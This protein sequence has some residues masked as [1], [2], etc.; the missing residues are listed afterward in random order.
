[1]ID[2]VSNAKVPTPA[3]LRKYGLSAEQWY[4]IWKLQGKICPICKK[5][6][7]TGKTVVDH[8]HYKNWKKLSADVRRS[9]VRGICC[10]YCNRW[11]VAK[12]MNIQKA[13]N[14]VA[15]L[16]N[17]EAHRKKLVEELK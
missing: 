4:A 8:F 12:G 10:W 13:K 2:T 6:P 16:E 11:H 15:Y 14:I 5:P 3:T 9:Y 7:S 17:Y 1:M